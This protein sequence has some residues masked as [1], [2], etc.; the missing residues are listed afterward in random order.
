[1]KKLE[2]EYK[3]VEF[4]TGH[5]VGD[6]IANDGYTRLSHQELAEHLGYVAGCPV[7]Q[8][9]IDPKNETPGRGAE[10]MALRYGE[11]SYITTFI[12]G[13]AKKLNSALYEQ[14]VASV[15]RTPDE[16]PILFEPESVP[17]NYNEVMAP[18]NTLAGYALPRILVEQYK[19]SK[20]GK[21]PTDV[22]GSQDLLIRGLEVLDQAIKLAETPTQLAVILAEKLV[23][24][25]ASP[26][27]VLGHILACGWL[28]EHNSPT[29]VIE[30]KNELCEHAP[31][32]WEFY[33]ALTSEEKVVLQ[34][35]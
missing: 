21:V 4:G 11:I 8:A 15:E 30:M 3:P 16:P 17:D 14:L 25:D 24:K 33:K 19:G 27:R 1:M 2:P 13:R 10:A 26:Q 6:F 28:D 5:F 20:N 9:L 34:I 29:S 32:L 22:K 23:L 12:Q 35:L 31:N 7:V 18:I